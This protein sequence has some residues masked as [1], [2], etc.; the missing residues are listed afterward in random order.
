MQFIDII[1]IEIVIGF[2]ARSRWIDLTCHTSNSTLR[3]NTRYTIDYQIVCS[4]K[5]KTK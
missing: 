1:P 4:F 5:F 3:D 2:R